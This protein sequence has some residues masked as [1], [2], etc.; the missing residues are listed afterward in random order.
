[1]IIRKP[2]IKISTSN[3]TGTALPKL[4]AA[5]TS[6]VLKLNEENITKAGQIPP[7]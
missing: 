2:N 1:M 5:L 6:R 7:H 4:K 3:F